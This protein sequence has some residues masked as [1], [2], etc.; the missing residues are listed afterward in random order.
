MT[1][2][3]PVHYVMDD[4]ESVVD[5]TRPLMAEREQRIAESVLVRARHLY[6]LDPGPVLEFRV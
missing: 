3:A 1:W 2:R 6:A 4:V 5:W